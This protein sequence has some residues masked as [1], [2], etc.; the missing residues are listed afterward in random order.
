MSEINKQTLDPHLH[1]ISEIVG[2]QATLDA[3]RLPPEGGLQGQVL[4]KASNAW[5]DFKWA[6][7]PVVLTV[8]AQL[9]GLGADD[10]PQYLTV[11]RA[12]IWYSTKTTDDLPE[13]R[14]NKYM[15]LAGSGTACT[16]ARSDHAHAQ[17]AAVGHTHRL[18]DVAGLAE[19]LD[20][21][22]HAVH[23]HLVA[24]VTGLQ[25]AL[26]SKASIAHA[27]DIAQ[28]PGLQTALDAKAGVSH[29]HPL[30]QV[31]GLAEAI[32]ARAPAVH[33]HNISAVSGLDVA[34][35]AKADVVHH[36]DNY[37]AVVHTHTIQEVVN[38]QAALNSKSDIG[39][40]H[41]YSSTFAALN[42][43]HPGLLP[44]GGMG[45]QV[46]GK[47]T[48]SDFDLSWVN[49]PVVVTDHSGLSGLL[50]DGH[51][52]YLTV[53][54]ADNWL[55]TKSSD[56]VAEGQFNRYLHLAGTGSSTSAARADHTHDYSRLFAS[57]EHTHAGLYAPV[58][59]TH[60][61]A[62]V[63][64]LQQAIDAKAAASHQHQIGHVAGL[65]DALDAKAAATHQHHVGHVAGLQAA[66]DA[67]ASVA[68]T[69][70]FSGQF[71]AITH[72]HDGRYAGLAHSHQPADVQGLQAAL[73][74]K[75]DAGHGHSASEIVGLA[76]A[77]DTKSDKGHTHDFTSQ[78]APL[79]HDHRG[80]YAAADH[81]HHVASVF[82]L[83]AAL[84]SKADAGHT[85]AVADTAGLQAV[86]DGKAGLQHSHTLSDVAGLAGI[87]DSKASARH[88]H[89]TADIQG[90]QSA[91]DSKASAG[92]A[93]DSAYSRLGH[94]HSV[95]E[96]AGLQA[97]LDSR[98]LAGHTHD[99]SQD[100]AALGHDHDG[101]Y[102]QVG[103]QHTISTISNLQNVLDSKANVQ[104]THAIAH[105]G[106][107]Q[108]V[109]DAKSNVGHQH[110]ISGVAGLQSALDAKMPADWVPQWL[111]PAGGTQGQVLTKASDRSG[112]LIW[113]DPYVAAVVQSQDFSPQSWDETTADA[114]MATK[115][116]DDL[117]EGHNNKYVHFAGTG[118]AATVARSDHT[119]DYAA[120]YAAFTH[121][122]AIGDVVGLEAR[123]GTFAHV[124]HVHLISD[125]IGL[126]DSLDA[127]ADWAH[128]HQ[129]GDITG[130]WNVLDDMEAA[131]NGKAYIAHVHPVA[132]IQGL[133]DTLTSIQ[134]GLASKANAVHSHSMDDVSGL[135]SALAGKLDV[136]WVPHWLAPG[137]GAQGQLL[138]KAS[139]LDGDFAWVD[140]TVVRVH[141]QLTGLLAD[142][143]P[144]YY[145][146]NRI[147]SWL[148]SKTTDDLAQGVINKYMVLAGSGTA[149]TA[150][151]SDHN[152]AG[153][154]AEVLHTHTVSQLS[155]FPAPQ[156]GRY[157]TSSGGSLVW[158]QVPVTLPDQAGQP[159][160][161]L[162]TD[163]VTATWQFPPSYTTDQIPEGQTNKY[164]H[165]G[166]SGSSP[167]AARIDHTHYVQDLLD[168]PERGGNSGKVLTTDGTVLIWA[169]PSTGVPLV[170]GQSGKWLTTDGV[171]TVWA[172]LPT[173]TTS[174]VIESGT[175]F[176]FTDARFEA[177]LLSKDT[178]YLPEGAIHKY[179]HL[180]GNG[181]AETAARSD[182]VHSTSMLTDFPSQ[183]GQAGN[184]LVTDGNSLYWG[185]MSYS[186]PS[187]TPQTLGG[188]PAGTTFDN[189][190]LKQ[191]LDMLLYP[192]QTPAVSAFSVTNYA[193]TLEVGAQVPGPVN[194]SFSFTNAEN[195]A[196]GSVGIVDQNG[197]TLVSGLNATDSPQLLALPMTVQKLAP[198]SYSWTLT[199]TNTLGQAI[200]RSVSISWQWKI[201]WGSSTDPAL[202]AGGVAGLASSQLAGGLARTYSMPTGGYK[203]FAWPAS[204][205]A[206]SAIVDA[207]TL[208][209]LPF[210]P[211]YQVNITNVQGQLTTYNVYRSTNIMNASVNI[212]VS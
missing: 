167:I 70:D 194:F 77:L 84:G 62:E 151:R 123:M 93:H 206:P 35:S 144:Q 157:L 141:G 79:V 23:T 205:G 27:H 162:T 114:W 32:S 175:N 28:I 2:L 130:L 108:E 104:H 153:L 169:A 159:G 176:Y 186:N 39:H 116:T 209:P 212:Q 131:I 122:H 181:V 20:V 51:P 25:A 160:R 69:H 179:M 34:L 8:H 177:A 195:V 53:N 193:A 198:G 78:F 65:Q 101:R 4:V 72:N 81:R 164:M 107:L 142:D 49:L 90:L 94:T 172:S 208:L 201:F 152:H 128:P 113:V 92:H 110:T 30:D 13:G 126:T 202:D 61:I 31:A 21:K 185:S 124:E 155:D 52:Q 112:D 67:K 100:F 207:S 14:S 111:V 17:Y 24:H 158:T 145:N 118:S 10:H 68:H 98:S 163:G 211:F 3:L 190:S 133:Q 91:L 127:K 46:L 40:S 183:S 71:A 58:L 82:G 197:Y 12:N 59:H 97:A 47:K 88:V 38:L 184:V 196:A 189:H 86:L 115:T 121:S 15:V 147:N 180:D 19:A 37:A 109:L 66:L 36:H 74:A 56:D 43:T 143:H 178:D 6:N 138:A 76:A 83:E 102:A 57:I 64:G 33:Q 26:D 99:F 44:V 150:A 1:S 140:E 174:D 80:V 85:H 170:I 187:P 11:G 96:I 137:G 73:D 5:G 139:G 7:Q 45:G 182:H 173:Y 119:H 42:H 75:S 191:I 87:L 171:S 48:G 22:A 149:A 166:G 50:Q 132:D 120:V 117:P 106:G 95:V 188:I 156:D 161:W 134:V 129:I 192:Y 199:A 103:H 105:V 125:I 54:R 29:V 154:Y 89:T 9:S 148:S 41:D 165:L 16:A 135:Q 200:S 203:Y 146:Y 63:L 210:Q 136:G 18:T 204:F 60:S 55:D 168:F